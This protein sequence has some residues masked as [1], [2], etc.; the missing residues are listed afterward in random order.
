MTA[1]P[2]DAPPLENAGVYA[3]RVDAVAAQAARL[4][5]TRPHADRWGGGVTTR[6]RVD[7]HRPLEPLLALLSEEL[8]PEDV[9]LDV[10][11]GAGRI[12]L[13][14]ASRCREVVNVEPS[15]GMAA[16][17]RA[18]AR[19]AGIT[20][21]RTVEADW[22]AA[23]ERGDV[24]IVAHVTYFVR[25]IVP[26]VEKLTTVARK[27]VAI[28]IH[29]VAPPGLHDDVFRI[30][31]DESVEAGP[32]HRELLPVLWD[33]GLLPEVHVLPRDSNPSYPTREAAIAGTQAALGA[34][35]GVDVA[36]DAALRARLQA[37]FEDLYRPTAA[38]FERLLPA[39]HRVLV[40]AWSPA[41]RTS[42][43]YQRMGTRRL[44]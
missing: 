42:A 1:Y 41:A 8:T 23:E 22:L 30:L 31:C 6:F 44:P 34:I 27:R 26:F 39:T 37:R 38:G 29:S 21:I 9:L 25:E 15:P 4:F 3:A 19:E 11:G 12:S 40:I 17:F 7:P 5:G 18:V 32:G 33:L 10:G 36:G 2:T 16:A 43:T 35:V 20:N 28:V 24:A 13:P 14:L